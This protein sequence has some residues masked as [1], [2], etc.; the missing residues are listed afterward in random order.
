LVIFVHQLLETCQRDAA[1]LY[2]TLIAANSSILEFDDCSALLHGPVGLKF[3]N[4]QPKV[5]P[6]MAML[7]QFMN[8]P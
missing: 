7:Q 5:N 6:V 3:F 2:K 8:S 1:Q 4:I